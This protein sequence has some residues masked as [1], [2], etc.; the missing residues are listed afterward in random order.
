MHNDNRVFNVNGQGRDR[1]TETIGLAF[2]LSGVDQTCTGYAQTNEHGL[3]L[4]AWPEKD[5]VCLPTEFDAILTSDICWSWLN[6]EKSK[7]I[8]LNGWDIDSDHDGHNTEGW[9]VYLEDWGHVG[10]YRSAICAVRPAFMWHG[11]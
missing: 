7:D 6:S 1:L 3:I 11:K 10:E 4:L 9:R 2:N 8:V 5:C